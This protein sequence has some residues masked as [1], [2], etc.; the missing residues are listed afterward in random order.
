MIRLACFTVIALLT[1]CSEYCENRLSSLVTLAWHYEA[2]E[3]A[4]Y[5]NALRRTLLVCPIP[6]DGVRQPPG[7]SVHAAQ[8][9][10]LLN[11]LDSATESLRSDR[12]SFS[13]EQRSYLLSYAVIHEDDRF[14]QVL[15]DSGVDL[16]VAYPETG[17]TTLMDAAHA[18]TKAAARMQQ[19]VDLGVD[20]FWTSVDGLS[21][22]DSAVLAE[23]DEA[24]EF[25][26]HLISERDPIPLD[27]VLNA[28][29][30]AERT[31]QSRASYL[32]TWLDAQDEDEPQEALQ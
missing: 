7:D 13:D 1:G 6:S 19:L 5:V 15:L 28:I 26:L 30:I 14:L 2:T 17:V 12:Y 32:K 31:D 4:K 24:V 21:A 8:V 3:N 18:G 20:P 9:Y 16:R 23:S 27:L 10:F 22:L 29:S 25:M 11:D